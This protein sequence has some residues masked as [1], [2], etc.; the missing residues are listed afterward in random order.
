MP[1]FEKENYASSQSE[2]TH[3][4]LPSS[5]TDVMRLQVSGPGGWIYKSD[6]QVSAS[7]IRRGWQGHA[8]LTRRTVVKHIAL[9]VQKC[10]TEAGGF[11]TL[12]CGHQVY[13]EDIF[14]FELLRVSDG[15]YQPLLAYRILH[16]FKVEQTVDGHSGR[17][18]SGPRAPRPGRCISST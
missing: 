14:L 16:E 7:C 13:F 15:S 10:L 8:P 6:R 1:V 9:T 4:S 17:C 2:W 18:A 5:T 3:I 11:W 12:P